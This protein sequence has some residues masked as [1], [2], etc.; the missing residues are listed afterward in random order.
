MLHQNSTSETVSSEIWSF[1]LD[2]EADL[3]DLLVSFCHSGFPLSQGKI[4]QIVW[5]YAEENQITG[6]SHQK[7]KAGQNG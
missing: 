4:R 5:Q 3:A 7:C 2:D 6:F 1:N